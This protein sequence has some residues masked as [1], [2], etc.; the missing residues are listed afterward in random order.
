MFLLKLLCPSLYAFSIVF[1][2][3]N[4]SIKTAPDPQCSSDLRSFTFHNVSI[5]TGQHDRHGLIRC[6]FTFHNVSIKTC[7][8][9]IYSVYREH[10]T[11]H[12]VSIKTSMRQWL[13]P[14]PLC[15]TFHNVSIKTIS[16]ASKPLMFETLHSTMFLLKRFPLRRNLSA[17]PSLHS[18][19]FLLTQSRSSPGHWYLG[20][21]IPQCFY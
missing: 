20:L 5:K 15:F 14:F 13:F 9:G 1:T 10:F 3:H 7:I 17:K 19:M 18:T 6:Y 11:F 8:A 21:Y 16:L 2:F 4:V 12:N